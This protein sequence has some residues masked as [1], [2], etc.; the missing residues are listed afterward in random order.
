MRAVPGL[1]GGE[2]ETRRV[3][4]S[5]QRRIEPGGRNR[6]IDLPTR[7]WTGLSTLCVLPLGKIRLTF[8]PPAWER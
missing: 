2:R 5:N 4:D 3:E 6:A 7:K 8:G 1:F